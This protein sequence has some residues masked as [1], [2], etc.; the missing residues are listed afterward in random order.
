MSGSDNVG[1]NTILNQVRQLSSD[2]RLL[3]TT[4]T[5]ILKYTTLEEM[6]KIILFAKLYDIPVAYEARNNYY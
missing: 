1:I 5:K 3:E 2:A 6:R 4:T